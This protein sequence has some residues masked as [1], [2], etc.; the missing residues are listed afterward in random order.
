MGVVT[1]I[2]S[3]E[4]MCGLMCDNRLPGERFLTEAEYN[5]IVEA[6][7]RLRSL[8]Y[9]VYEIERVLRDMQEYP[10]DFETGEEETDWIFTFGEDQPHEGK[11]VR[12]HGTFGQARREMIRMF[13]DEWAFQ[14]HIDDWNFLVEEGRATETE[15][16]IGGDAR[17]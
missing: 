15:L 2:N 9:D 13:G 17:V 14:Y 6:I 5:Q 10:E 8:G 7:N 12:I 11:F 4:D 1:K 16:E 3:L